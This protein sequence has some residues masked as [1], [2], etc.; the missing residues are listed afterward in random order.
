MNPFDLPGPEFLALYLGLLF[1]A[2]TFAWLHKEALIARQNKPARLTDAYAVARLR[3]G[4][5][6][7]VRLAIA[8][9][10]HLGRF[11]LRSSRLV[12]GPATTPPE[13]P[14]ERALDVELRLARE[15]VEARSLKRAPAID[16]VLDTLEDPLRERGLILDRDAQRR[17]KRTRLWL[18]L[19]LMTFGLIKLGVALDRDHHNVLFLILLL[20]LTPW[21]LFRR[22]FEAPATAGGSAT[23]EGLGALLASART[24]SPTS[25]EAL[26][27]AATLG[28]SVAGWD[29]TLSRAFPP[30]SGGADLSGGSSCGSGCGGGCGGCGS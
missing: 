21:L 25:P 30:S 18:T 4:R 7:P 2:L 9:L 3:A 14:L 16:H 26:F 19:G 23:L 17:L 27:I 20:G 11:A 28:P 22:T 1:A 15:P 5:K 29:P 8:R 24:A 10:L 6:E 13:H 12:P